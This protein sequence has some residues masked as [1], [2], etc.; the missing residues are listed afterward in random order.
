MLWSVLIWIC[1]VFSL[2]NCDLLISHRWHPVPYPFCRVSSH[3]Y[4]IGKLD[5][6]GSL[7]VRLFSMFAPVDPLSDWFRHTRPFRQ[8]LLLLCFTL[9]PLP[10][11]DF[12]QFFEEL[13]DILHVLDQIVLNSEELAAFLLIGRRYRIPKPSQRVLIR[14]FRKLFD[15]RMH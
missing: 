3:P 7:Q 5:S 9:P 12:R 14:R 10:V 6:C 4:R 8:R 15:L 1:M 2:G 13:V 11:P